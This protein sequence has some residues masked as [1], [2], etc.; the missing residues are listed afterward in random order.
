MCDDNEVVRYEEKPACIASE[1][2]V[3]QVYDVIISAVKELNLFFHFAPSTEHSACCGGNLQP[4]FSL[5]NGCPFAPASGIIPAMNALI[6]VNP[7]AGTVAARRKALRATVGYLTEHGWTTTWRETQPDRSATALARQAVADDYDTVVV[8][9]GDGTIN[10]VIQPLVGTDVRLGV[11]P[12][13]TANLWSMECGIATA[14]VLMPQNLQHAADVLVH[15]ETI[16]ADV[17]RAGTRYFL[18]VA[19]IGFD[20]TVTHQV[21]VA[22][23]RRLGGLAYLWKA[24]PELPRSRGVSM[25]ITIDGERFHRR[26]L[27]VTISNTRLY[28]GLTLAPEA[29]FTDGYLDVTIFQGRGWPALIKFAALG[30]LGF[31]IQTPEIMRMRG[32]IIEIEGN[33]TLPIQVDA[34]PLAQTTPIRVEVVPRS[35]HVIVPRTTV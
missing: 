28:A 25:S 27:L 7:V 19:G 3:F 10:E 9:G 4:V 14:P 26:V 16:R 23:K 20:A 6:I 15:G 11:L 30:L 24:L 22:T 21:D 31:R 8:A 35:L 33:H 1:N 17:G 2:T 12:I 5:P 13:G 29:S 32:R 34:E 18:L